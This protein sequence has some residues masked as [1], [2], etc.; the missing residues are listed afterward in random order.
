[1]KGSVASGGRGAGAIPARLTNT[2]RLGIA[3]FLIDRGESLKR[4]RILLLQRAPELDGGGLYG[5][6]G[7]RVDPGENWESAIRREVLEEVGVKIGDVRQL[8]WVDYTD[9]QGQI[10]LTLFV[11]ATDWFGAPQNC[12]PLK[13]TRLDWL[14]LLDLADPESKIPLFEPLR[15]FICERLACDDLLLPQRS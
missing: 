6:P 9:K 3:C 4:T 5:L 13:H 1:M 14:S 15:A 7:G 10:W 2:M 11:R 8:G 12:E